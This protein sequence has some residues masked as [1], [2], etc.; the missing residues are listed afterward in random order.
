MPIRKKQTCR[1]RGRA[2]CDREA[3]GA[4]RCYNKGL[5][6]MAVFAPWAVGARRS[7][8]KGDFTAAWAVV[9]ALERQS[10]H[11]HHGLGWCR[12]VSLW[13]SSWLCR[14]ERRR[15]TSC[16][17]RMLD[18]TGNQ[19]ENRTSCARGNWAHL[20]KL[21]QGAREAHNAKGAKAR[22]GLKWFVCARGFFDSP[23]K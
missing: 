5:L 9:G 3:E 20:I 23:I 4:G 15:V 17:G 21:L 12:S 1:A 2:V 10:C 14:T 13:R 16:T 7:R 8:E 18:I 6:L 19:S 22:R 11:R